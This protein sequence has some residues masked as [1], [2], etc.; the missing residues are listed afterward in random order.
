MPCKNQGKEYFLEA[1]G[2]IVRQ[3]S[4]AWELLILTDPSSPPEIAEWAQSFSDPRIRVLQSP[5]SGFARALN[6]GLKEAGTGFV[7]ILLSDDRYTPDAVATLLDYRARF[8]QA[9]FFHSARRHIDR[10]G[11][12]FGDDMPPRDPVLLEDFRSWG[13]PVKHLMCWRREMALAI[14][15]MDESLSVHG[16]DDYDFPWRMAEA[17]AQFQA[18]SECLYE[19]RLHHRHDRLT[20]ATPVE[21]QIRTLRR[22]FERHGVPPA[23]TDHYIDRAID[24]Y[25]TMEATD[26]VDHDRGAR[27]E[28]QCFR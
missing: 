7:S 20:T 12:L 3:T 15:G 19:Y 1:A 27:I 6:L 21:T 16:C 14:G 25:L 13:S 11:A 24:G 22:M 17:G 9:D 26:Q 18:V 2:S 28:V 4:P 5:E 10:N 23:K 8:E